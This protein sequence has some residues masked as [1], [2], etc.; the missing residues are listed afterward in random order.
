[1][2]VRIGLMLSGIVVAAAT[3]YGTR[4]DDRY[5]DLAFIRDFIAIAA[6]VIGLTVIW[7]GVVVVSLVTRARKTRRTAP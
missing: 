2:A 3:F 7:L 6:A 1:M 5:P 4:E